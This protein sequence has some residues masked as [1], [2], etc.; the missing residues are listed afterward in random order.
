MKN[1]VRFFAI[2]DMISII[3]L[4]KQFWGIITHLNE[5]PDQL[6]SQVKVWLTL[7][8]F[9][10]LFV[11]TMGLLLFRKFGFI[12]YYVQFPFRLI[13]WI[14]SIGFITYLPELMNLSEAW[15]NVLFRVCFIAE[16]F[17]LY[18]TIQIHR[19]YF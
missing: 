14:F 11:S 17:R 12:A 7:F 5:I 2:L 13:I 16:F 15:F 8:L 6:V 18:F 10:L 19:R 1:T 4:T 9:V 3:L